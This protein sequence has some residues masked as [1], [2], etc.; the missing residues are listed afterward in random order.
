MITD[1]GMGELSQSCVVLKNKKRTTTVGDRLTV[2]KCSKFSLLLW[3]AVSEA[4]FAL[5]TLFF[6]LL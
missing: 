3:Q 4:G 6:M 2:N 5:F 1:V